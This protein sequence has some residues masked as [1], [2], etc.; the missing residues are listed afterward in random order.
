MGPNRLDR[1]RGRFRGAGWTLALAVAVG[2]S[3][4]AGATGGG[5]GTVATSP[6]VSGISRR[7]L[8][9]TERSTRFAFSA[10]EIAAT[11][12]QELG[13]GVLLVTGKR[14]DLDIEVRLYRQSAVS[15]LVDV[16]VR[17]TQVDYDNDFGQQLLDKIVAG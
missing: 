7:A 3:A 13:D 17:R 5:A 14:K 4:C 11:G 2:L 16:R 10:L 9:D 1:H 12:T 6:G 8:W 15:T